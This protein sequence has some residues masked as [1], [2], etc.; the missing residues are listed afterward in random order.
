MANAGTFK[1][2]E[3]RPGQGRPK[4]QLSKHTVA[5]KDAIQLAA[6]GLGGTERLIAW[7]KEDPANE[8]A[9]WANIYPKL[10]PLQVTGANGGPLEVVG[11]TKEQRDA[12]VAAATRADT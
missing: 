8:R 1:K 4:G 11:M 7:A 9:F 2:G 10:L 5:V 6:E 3:K 12:S